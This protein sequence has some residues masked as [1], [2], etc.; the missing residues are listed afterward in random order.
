LGTNLAKSRKRFV[1]REHP[2]SKIARDFILARNGNSLFP[3]WELKSAMVLDSHHET[4]SQNHL[5][6][7]AEVGYFLKARNSRISETFDGSR[8]YMIV[9]GLFFVSPLPCSRD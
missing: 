1:F 2:I 5:E 8:R 7:G 9:C 4:I 6:Y 3:F